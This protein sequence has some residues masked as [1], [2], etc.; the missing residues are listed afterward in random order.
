M[1]RN[2]ALKLGFFSYL[3]GDGPAT[4]IYRNVTDLFVRADSLGLDTG[5]VAQHHFGHH[6]GLPSPF[7]FFSADRRSNPGDRARHGRD[8]PRP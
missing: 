2:G 8:H 7:V 5:W 6:G 3:E 1:A 4:G